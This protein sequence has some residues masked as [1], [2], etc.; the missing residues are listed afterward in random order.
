MPHLKG[1]DARLG[2]V[3]ES[4]TRA[5]IQVSGCLAVC[6]GLQQAG[7]GGFLWPRAYRHYSACT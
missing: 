2:G 4:Q 6:W 5:C 1:Q 3:G 7:C